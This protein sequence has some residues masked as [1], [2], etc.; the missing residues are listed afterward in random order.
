MKNEIKLPKG[1]RLVVFGDC[2]EHEEQF[3]KLLEEV[4]PDAKTLLVSVGDIYDKGFGRDAAR[5]ITDKFRPLVKTGCGY[6]I[7]GNHELTS[8]RWAKHQRKMTKQLTW[9]DKQ[10]LSLTFTFPNRTKVTV[11]HGGVLP[12]YNWEDLATNIDTCYV[13]FVDKEGKKIKRLKKVVDDRRVMVMEKPGKP[14]HDL[15]EGRFGYIVSGHNS[16]KDGIAK[17]YN[18]S[19]N[20]DT[21]VYYTGKLTAQVF[22]DGMKK[23]LLTFVGTPKYPD[24]EEMERLMNKGR[25]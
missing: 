25:I 14:W 19:C 24:F 20:L 13:R 11:V 8:I 23:E 6:V 4:K 22:E 9:W 15:Y 7:K 10:P 21:A 16:Q 17:F 2:H 5:S 1:V 18:Y 12:S 3:D